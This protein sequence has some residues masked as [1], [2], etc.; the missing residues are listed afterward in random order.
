MVIIKPLK[1]LVCLL[2][3]ATLSIVPAGWCYNGSELLGPSSIQG[4]ALSADPRSQP[5]QQLRSRT[6]TVAPVQAAP[7]YSSN[8][9]VIRHTANPTY[10]AAQNA[11]CPP[12]GCAVPNQQYPPVSSPFGLFSPQGFSY[13]SCGFYLFRPGARQW[14]FN[15]KLWYA[16]LNS[17]TI[18]WGTNLAGGPGTELDF[19]RDLGLS[20]YRYIPE[21]EGRYNLR[22]NWGIRFSFMPLMYSDNS[23]PQQTFFFGNN[24][25]PLGL[26]ILT[27]WERFIYRWDLV[28]DWFQAPHA[29]SSIF[30]GYSL[31][32]D[33]LSVSN[34]AARRTRSRGFGLAYAGGSIDRVIRNVGCGAASV[35]CKASVQFLEGFIGWDGYATGRFTVPM[36]CGRY[37]Y[38][39]AGWRWM[40]LERSYPTDKDVTS[41]DGLTGAV[42]LVF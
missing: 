14:Q 21:Y 28:Y 11:Y 9:A 26:P 33:K 42:G 17:T 2:I 1:V 35:H 6:R 22:C 41:L 34:T 40:V 23:V 32:D 12:Q 31:Y 37:G 3:L 18:L 4:D 13:G 38:I 16:K 36:D 25:Y 8:P 19:Q 15:A 10:G 29:V 20:K 27:K 7:T 39:E 5:T 30:A 24:I